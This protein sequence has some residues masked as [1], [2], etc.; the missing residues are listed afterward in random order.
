MC[1]IPVSRHASAYAHPLHRSFEDRLERAFAANQAGVSNAA[2][3]PALDVTDTEADYVAVLDMPGVAKEDIKVT[4]DG[5]RV[6]VQ[7]EASKAESV[8]DA[9]RLIHRERT[10]NPY[11]RSFVLPA[12]IEQAA[13]QARLEQGV[14]TLTLPKRQ[15][16]TAAHITVN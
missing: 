2:R 8:D 13:S 1:V 12:D 6:T 7:A 3:T 15:L 10:A 4:V 14:L 16:R 5:R 9:A 11:A